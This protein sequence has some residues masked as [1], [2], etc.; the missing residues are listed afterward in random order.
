[1]AKQI[2]L[3]VDDEQIILEALQEQLD[4]SFGD[5][6]QI[7]T[8]DSGKD[9]LEFCTEL[10]DEGQQIPVI[11][12]DYMMPGMKGDEL[13]QKIHE[14]SP[15]SLKILLT[16]QASIEGITNAINYAKLY[17]YIAKPWDK[18]DLVLTVK[19]AI[20]SLFLLN[21]KLININ[22]TFSH[23]DNNFLKFFN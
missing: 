6:F 18:D 2:I 8:S 20:K 15:G 9:A 16:G 12:S 10:I 11:I 22:K 23:S 19:E 14:L 5:E 13:L 1:M 3:C 4:S 7:E 21:S 17:R